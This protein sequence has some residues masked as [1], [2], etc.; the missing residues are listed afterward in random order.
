VEKI[1][2]KTKCEENKNIKSQAPNHKF[3]P[4]SNDQMSKTKKR[5]AQCLRLGHWNLELGICLE[6]GICDLEFI[7]SL[8]TCH[9]L[10]GASLA[11]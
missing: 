5:N 8:V 10:L 6:F 1:K 9:L 2:A 4:S 3:A 11:T 7:S